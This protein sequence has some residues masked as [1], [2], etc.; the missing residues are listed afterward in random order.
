MKYCT[1]LSE[2]P[3][4][5]SPS[6]SAYLHVGER[7]ERETDRKREREGEAAKVLY[8]TGTVIRWQHAGVSGTDA[9]LISLLF[10]ADFRLFS[11]CLHSSLILS[12]DYFLFVLFLGKKTE[13]LFF[14]LTYCLFVRQVIRLT[15]SS[16][17]LPPDVNSTLIIKRHV[18]ESSFSQ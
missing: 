12:F 15:L 10:N 18:S 1:S 17:T 6:K 8:E 2:N 7:K 9:K 5:I 13:I 3:R 4:P 16:F 11:I 14:C